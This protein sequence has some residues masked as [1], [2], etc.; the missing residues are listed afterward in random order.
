LTA[1]IKSAVNIEAAPSAPQ[2]INN[3][4]LNKN[5]TNELGVYIKIN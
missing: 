2:E 5:K 3:I 1:S 4:T